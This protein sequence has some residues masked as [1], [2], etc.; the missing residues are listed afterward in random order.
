MIKKQGNISMAKQKVIIFVSTKMES[1]RQEAIRQ[2]S[3][4]E[5]NRRDLYLIITF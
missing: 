4:N 2:E 1:K 5:D 3:D